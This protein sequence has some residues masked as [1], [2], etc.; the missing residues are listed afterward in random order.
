M[1][2]KSAEEQLFHFAQ[3]QAARDEELNAAKNK[4]NQLAALLQEA[5]EMETKHM[6]QEKILK[7]EIRELERAKKREEGA[8]LEYLKNV[9]I[10]WILTGEQEVMFSQ[11]MLIFTVCSQ[12]L[13]PVLSTVLQ[14]SPEEVQKVRERVQSRSYYLCLWCAKCCVEKEGL[15][16]TVP[17]IS[18]FF[19][20]S[21][22]KKPNG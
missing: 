16:N 7:Q 4:I 22:S 12:A 20:S 9:V 8:N 2:Y 1:L 15:W 21:P 11:L 13:L 19:W 10:N 3:I 18:N 14:F 17:N 6:E 5:E